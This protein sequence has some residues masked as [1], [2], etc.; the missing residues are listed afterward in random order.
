MIVS[1]VTITTIPQ[2]THTRPTEFDE[3]PLANDPAKAQE[4]VDCILAILNDNCPRV[5]ADKPLQYAFQAIWDRIKTVSI[6]LS[7][8]GRYRLTG[9]Y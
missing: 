5:Q 2:V 4:E 6:L 7:V 9:L 1:F 3:G 8:Q